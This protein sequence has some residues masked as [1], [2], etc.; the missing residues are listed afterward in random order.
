MTK[1]QAQAWANN[2]RVRE[3]SKHEYKETVSANASSNSGASNSGIGG[4][5]LAIVLAGLAALVANLK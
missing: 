4:L 2:L 5:C 3:D 1:K